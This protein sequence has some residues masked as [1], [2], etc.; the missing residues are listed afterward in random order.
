MEAA[1][2]DD[3]HAIVSAQHVI[4]TSLSD[5]LLAMVATLVGS[6]IDAISAWAEWW[7]NGVPASDRVGP[8]SL[9]KLTWP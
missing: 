7:L 5:E 1:L 4:H 8:M 6:Y 3:E 2:L 9:E